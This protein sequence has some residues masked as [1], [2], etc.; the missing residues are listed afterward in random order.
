MKNTGQ[1]I[2]RSRVASLTISIAVGLA[3]AL[4][5]GAIA[6]T[7]GHDTASALARAEAARDQLP[8]T[9]VMSIFGRPATAADTLP[10]VDRAI[11]RGFG[12]AA[13]GAALDPGSAVLAQ[14]R[15]AIAG[16]G[17]AAAALYLV[18]TD[19]GT[20]CMV[21]SP[22]VYPGGCSQ[23]FEPGTDIVYVRGLANGRTVIFGI[24]K[25]GVTSVTAVV[26]GQDVPVTVGEN[27]FFYEG[28]ALPE[29][30]LVRHADGGADTLAVPPMNRLN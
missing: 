21:W 26:G 24:V 16:A 10:A 14:S 25:D 8:D 15:R 28:S 3:L 20:V 29:Q 12:A 4:S 7:R 6:S 17:P 5:V 13:V 30:L 27:A 2:L 9:S 18:P 19:K 23:G 1:R 22:D 11:V